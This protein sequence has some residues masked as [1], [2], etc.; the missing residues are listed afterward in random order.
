MKILTILAAMSAAILPA[1]ASFSADMYQVAAGATVTINEHGT[2][3]KVTN[4]GSNPIMV[5]TRSANEWAAG[6]N[7]FLNNVARM[8]QVGLSACAPESRS[9]EMANFAAFRYSEYLC[10]VCINA[11]IALTESIMSSSFA[12][13]V[14]TNSSV[15]GPY[16]YRPLRGDEKSSLGDSII[17]D[18]AE[19]IIYDNMTGPRATATSKEIA[20]R[21]GFAHGESTNTE[22]QVIGD[23][24]SYTCTNDMNGWYV[25]SAKYKRPAGSGMSQN[26][27]T[28]SRWRDGSL[29]Y[30]MVPVNNDWRSGIWKGYTQVWGNPVSLS[31]EESLYYDLLITNGMPDIE[32]AM[33]DIRYTRY[34]HCG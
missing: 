8:S 30:S 28:L 19:V 10:E 15:A 5:P 6:A 24:G 4:G 16:G 27:M 33:T 18:S 29:L 12:E 14:A 22:A 3:M 17:L 13:Y 20:T 31:G 9:F 32:H 34:L 1:T 21:S 26:P 25:Y 2:C 23:A 11:E 7:A